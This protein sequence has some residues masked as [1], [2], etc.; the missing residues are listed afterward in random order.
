[1]DEWIKFNYSSKWENRIKRVDA[2]D[3]T[4]ELYFNDDFTDPV[5]IKDPTDPIKNEELKNAVTKHL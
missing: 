3:H 1:M 4:Y 5:K 2:E